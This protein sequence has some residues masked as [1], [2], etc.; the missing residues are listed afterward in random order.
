MNV[1]EKENVVPLDV[2]G[3][4]LYWDAST[5]MNA[6]ECRLKIAKGLYASRIRFH[7]QITSVNALQSIVAHVVANLMFSR[8]WLMQL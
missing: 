2:L 8:Y 7:P 1:D 4:S 3:C 5:R 6:I